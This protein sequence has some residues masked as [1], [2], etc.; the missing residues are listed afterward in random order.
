MAAN[1][2]VQVLLGL[3]FLERDGSLTAGKVFVVCGSVQ[4]SRSTSRRFNKPLPRIRLNSAIFPPNNRLHDLRLSGRLTRPLGEIGHGLDIS[5][6]VAHIVHNP[7][8]LLPHRLPPPHPLY[9][10]LHSAAVLLLQ[11]SRQFERIGRETASLR[12]VAAA[13][14]RV[15]CIS[16]FYFV[17]GADVESLIEAIHLA[18]HVLKLAAGKDLWDE[19]ELFFF[20]EVKGLLQLPHPILHLILH[21]LLSC[22]ETSQLRFG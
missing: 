16:I 2:C 11:L 18:L 22:E 5:V 20:A 14:P 19:G 1:G 10:P 8:P 7:L 17:F 3:G 4:R 13:R 9:E 15:L 6:S 12:E 21:L